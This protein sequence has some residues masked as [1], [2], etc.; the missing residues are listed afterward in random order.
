MQ[1]LALVQSLPLVR[2]LYAVSSSSAIVS[3]IGSHGLLFL[4]LVN[5]S[6]FPFPLIALPGGQ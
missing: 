4:S 3:H 6:T 1:S 2:S 5:L